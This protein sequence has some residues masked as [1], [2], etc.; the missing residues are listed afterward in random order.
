MRLLKIQ[1]TTFDL[2][3]VCGYGEVYK[4]PHFTAGV[5]GFGIC[6]PHQNYVT[7][8]FKIILGSNNLYFSFETEDGALKEFK[9]FIKSYRK[10]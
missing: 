6:I 1:D 3:T 8:D 9:R 7:Y 4:R 2:S 10:K 5:L